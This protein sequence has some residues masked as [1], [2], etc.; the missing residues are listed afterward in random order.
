MVNNMSNLPNAKQPANAHDSVSLGTEIS[1]QSILDDFSDSGSHSQAVPGCGA[2]P[3]LYASP[4][5]F[6]D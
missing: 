2:A 5:L 4:W 6:Q 3:G 1:D